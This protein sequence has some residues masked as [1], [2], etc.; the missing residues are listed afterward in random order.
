MN[1]RIINELIDSFGG[2]MAAG[3][4]VTLPLTICAF[5]AGLV[6]AFFVA[7]VQIANIPILKRVARIYVWFIR[8]TPMIVQLF[9]V[10]H[11]P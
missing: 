5:S 11:N 6:V 1:E 7:L 9:M 10:Y 4:K 8:G 2:L 3:L